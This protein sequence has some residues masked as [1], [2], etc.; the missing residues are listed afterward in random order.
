MT[1]LQNLLVNNDPDKR[2]T[3]TFIFSTILNVI[4][5]N[6][7]TTDE[8]QFISSFYADR[9]KDHHKVIINKLKM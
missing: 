9:S 3:G 7:F 1:K 8:L 6:F 2:A 5:S 4:D